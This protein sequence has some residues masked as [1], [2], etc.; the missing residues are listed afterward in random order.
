MRG[1]YYFLCILGVTPSF[2]P[3]PDSLDPDSQVTSLELSGLSSTKEPKVVETR[4]MVGPE[5]LEGS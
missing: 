1:V 3:I 4:S 2:V 5:V